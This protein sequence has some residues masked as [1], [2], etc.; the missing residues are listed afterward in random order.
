MPLSKIRFSAILTMLACSSPMVFADA[1]S[2]AKLHA[3]AK[4]SEA[5]ARATALAKVPSGTV[6]STELENEHGKL[7]WSFDIAQI[8]SKDITEIHVDAKTGK[9]V[10]TEMETPKKQRHE[11]AAEKKEH[12]TY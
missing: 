2:Q 9:I 4:I 8:G 11:A 10:S 7:I 1:T 12:K 6:S 3:E 5:D